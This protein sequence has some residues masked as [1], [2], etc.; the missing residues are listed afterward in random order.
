MF[1]HVSVTTNSMW[2]RV[3]QEV[4]EPSPRVR[5]LMHEMAFTEGEHSGKALALI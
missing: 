5:G 2:Y 3:L 1:K 4:P